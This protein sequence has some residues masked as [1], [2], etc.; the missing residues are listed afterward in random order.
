[1][2]H[3]MYTV[4]FFCINT[5]G[6]LAVLCV[7]VCANELS[8]LCGLLTALQEPKPQSTHSWELIIST[9][10]RVSLKHFGLSAASRGS[11]PVLMPQFQLLLDEFFAYTIGHISKLVRWTSIGPS[12]PSLSASSLPGIP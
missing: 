5:A 4:L 7:Q 12:L 3:D 10:Q 8:G 9:R 6:I 2:A 11:P 1:V